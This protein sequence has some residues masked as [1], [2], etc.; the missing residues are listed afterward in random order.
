[1]LV[2]R[3]AQELIV[4]MRRELVPPPRVDGDWAER[5][6]AERRAADRLSRDVGEAYVSARSTPRG[7]LVVAAY[8]SLQAE[9]DR[10]FRAVVRGDAPDSVRIVFTHCQEPYGSDQELIHAVR[11]GRVLEIT[12]AAISSEPIHP[13]L[14]CEYGGAFDRFRA[15]HDLFGHARTG[16]GFDLQDELAAWRTQD[17]LHGG[18]ARL[19]LATELLAINSA[20]SILGEAPE[21]KA[22]LLEPELLRHLRT[23]ISPTRIRARRALPARGS[24]PEVVEHSD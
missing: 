21:H 9:T 17:R 7:A 2:A 13:L 1:M 20:R 3:E 5:Y 16:F 11:A 19:A 18:L 15:M 10:L 12:T 6:W 14:G 24:A 22:M 8:E 23:R 4:E